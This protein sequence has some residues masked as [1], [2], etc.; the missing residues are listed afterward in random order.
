MGRIEE[1]MAIEPGIRSPERPPVPGQNGGAV[2]IRDLTFAYGAEAGPVLHG[3]DLAVPAGKTLGIVGPVGAGKSTLLMLLPRLY[4]PP[5]GTVFVDGV[6]VRE[7]DLAD[8]RARI[9]A[10]PQETFL[11]GETVTRNIALGAR[12]GDLPPARIRE[13]AELAGIA[14]EIDHLPRGYDTLLGERGVNLSGGQKQRMAIARALARDPKILLLDDCLS[15]VDTRTESA[16][17]GNLRRVTR[18][19][20]T[21]IVSHRVSTVMEAHEIVVLTEGRVVE[22]GTHAELLRLG[23]IYADLHE[24]QRIE[25]AGEDA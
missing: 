3:I 2:E 19:R 4:D 12:D 7:L 15:S 13:C 1:V 8:L 5:P 9:G 18:D 6:D 10:V 14:K 25:A 16:I 20:T 22:R 17:L 24:R 11:F 21:L 23:G